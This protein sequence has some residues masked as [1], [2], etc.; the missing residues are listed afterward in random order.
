MWYHLPPTYQDC[1]HKLD[2]LVIRKEGDQL[3]RDFRVRRVVVEQA[4]TWLLENN[5]YYRVNQIHLS[6]DA[7]AQLPQDGNLSAL[8]SLPPDPPS[9]EQQAQVS[10]EDPYEAHLSRSFVPNAV[11]PLT[12]QETVRQSLQD[13]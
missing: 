13:C 5:A 10:E 2:V 9:I 3:H 11:H 4:F 1:P 8:T 12:E 7:L 6:Q